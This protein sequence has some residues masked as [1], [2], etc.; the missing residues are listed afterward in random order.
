MYRFRFS[1]NVPETLEETERQDGK[2]ARDFE[3]SFNHFDAAET[4]FQFL[5]DVVASFD[6]HFQVAIDCCASTQLLDRFDVANEQSLAH[7]R[8]S[9]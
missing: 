7:L 8:T 6:L 9:A 1:G 2:G 5:D 3:N 4:P